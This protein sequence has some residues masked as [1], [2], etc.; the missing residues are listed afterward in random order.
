[1]NNMLAP[2][3]KRR[4]KWKEEVQGWLCI[5]PVVLGIL[6]FTLVP[7][8]YAFITSFFETGIKVFSLTDWGT[9]VGLKNYTQNFTVYAYREQ[10][11]QSMKVT[12]VYA[13]INIPLQMVLGFLLA[14]FLNR[15]ARGIKAIRALFYL[16][17]LIPPVCSGVLWNQLTGEY[18][19]INGILAKV[20]ITGWAWFDQASTSMP[21]F[22]FINLFQIGGSMILW[23]AQLKNVPK[24]MYESAQL[25]GAS[26]LRQLLVITVPMVTPMILYN[27]IM[28]L[29]GTLQTYDTV[30]TLVDNGGKQNS[31][32]FYM[33]FIYGNRINKFGYTCALSFIL[34]FITAIL[35]CV[36]MKSS[37]WVYYG[38][39]G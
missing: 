24:S 21:S 3:Y 16:P 12:F 5:L 14:V 1:M 25:D 27:L 36:V 4:I 26:K 35:S 29:I 7:V 2:R 8:L 33:V 20:G 15:E 10:F 13:L 32:L 31:L 9:F 30:A 39:E 6:I 38:E 28:S 19:A 37:K 23:L 22:I 34:F 18:G 17:V 11:W